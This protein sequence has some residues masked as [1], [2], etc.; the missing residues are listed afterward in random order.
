MN[1]PSAASAGHTTLATRI[2]DWVNA[3]ESA[4]IPETVARRACELILDAVGCGLAA[5]DEPFATRTIASVSKLSGDGPRCVIGRPGG[6]PMRDAALLNGLLMH[7]LDFDDTHTDGVVHLTVGV[8]PA[9]LAVASQTGASGRAMLEACIAGLEV[10]ARLAAAARGGFHRQGWHPTALVG[11]FA[12]TITA[13]RLLRLDA[14]GLVRAQGIALSLA[15]GS[16]QFLDD[17]SW[18]KRL[19]PGWAAQAGITAASLAADGFPAPTEAY[20]GRFGLYRLHLPE[21]EAALERLDAAVAGL[22]PDGT[23]TPW[24][25]LRVAIKP[26]PA[27]HLLHG[28]TEAAITLHRRGVELGSIRRIVARVPADVVPVVCEPSDAKRRPRS[29]YEAKFSLPYAVATALLRGR[30]D[31]SDLEADALSAPA[32]L[33]LMDRVEYRTDPDTT[34]PRH[35]PGEVV[36]E[37]VDGHR[38]GQRI[39]VNLGHEERPLDRADVEAKF[40][41]N[42]RRTVDADRAVAIRDAILGLAGLPEA[43]ALEPLLSLK[44][45]PDLA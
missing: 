15:G 39:P 42:A 36:I 44:P 34:Y 37:F 35:Y 5:L 30:F 20:E 14:A 10:G 21:P 26:Y 8:L 18:T 43:R 29:D 19:H 16:L 1:G 31:L 38:I 41:A 2:A 28:A 25:T 22:H 17:G 27:C 4:R 13:G 40:H 11:T 3:L 23:A 6:L 33:D 24:E 7:G 12:A 45:I 32:A 9:A